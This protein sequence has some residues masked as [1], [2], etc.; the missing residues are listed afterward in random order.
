MIKCLECGKQFK[1][2]NIF[3]LKH[4]GLTE[5]LYLEKYPNAEIFSQETKDLIS[6]K[7][8]EGMHKEENW[9]RYRKGLE[10]RRTTTENLGKFSEKGRLLTEEEFNKSY[11]KERNEKISKARSEWWIGKVGKTVEDIFGEETGKHIREIK[12]IQ[13][14]GENNPAYGKVYEKSGGSKIGRYKGLLFRGIWEY[15]YWK[16]LENLG[17][18]ILDRN[19]V[20]YE[21]F[22][23]KYICDNRSRTYTPDFLNIKEKKLIEVKSLYKFKEM[24]SMLVAKKQ[25]AEEWCRENGYTYH[26]LTENDFPV[27][28]YSIAY[29]DPDVEWIRK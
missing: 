21:P 20:K 13:T 16:Y 1:R 9:S 7:T 22:K 12:S 4:H 8:K 18:N 24:S 15:S 11:S 28:T 2:I 10:S 25:Y 23:I 27:L 17:F 14:S 26:I 29:S 19:E 6:Q 3:H 5:K